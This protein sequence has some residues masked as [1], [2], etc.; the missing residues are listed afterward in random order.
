M[1]AAVKLSKAVLIEVVLG[2]EDRPTEEVG[3]PVEVQFNP[4]TLKV[5]YS[6]TVESGDN[7]GSSAMQFIAK[8]STKLS[9]DLWFDASYDADHTDVRALTESVQFF[10]QPRERTEAGETSFQIPAVRLRWGSFLFEGVVV[11]LDET[12]ELF[13]A[14]GRPLRAKMS[15]TITNQ[16]IRFRIPSPAAGAG[17]GAGAGEQPLTAVGQG[18]TVQDLAAR[19]GDASG[20]AAL[21]A[22][23]DVDN[24]RR[25]T[26]GSLLTPRGRS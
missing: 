14:D 2:D 5:T 4:E 7:P 10:V 3:D 11:S 17:S 26:P 16:D 8:N 19:S 6:N 24:P 15:M 20:W 25:P 12:I 22:A 23:N 9:F 21:A 18:Q 13:S 1:T